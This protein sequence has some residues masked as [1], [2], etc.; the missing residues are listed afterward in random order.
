MNELTADPARVDLWLAFCGDAQETSLLLRYRTLLTVEERAQADR[1]YFERDRLRYLVTRALVRTVL[2]R[3]ARIEPADWRFVASEYG[4]PLI[5][6]AERV[7]SGLSFNITHTSDLVTLAVTRDRAIGIDT[8]SLSRDALLDIADRYFAPAEY[9]DLRALPATDQPLRFF[10]LWTLKE[11][12]IKARGMGLS[13]PLDRFAFDLRTPGRVSLSFVE[14]FDDQPQRWHLE[15]RWAT[16]Q[17]P[18]ALCVERRGAAPIVQAR[19]VVPLCREAS[20]DVPL[21]RR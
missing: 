16:P 12:Y 3:Y 15:Q 4:R 17:H 7:A 1:F 11:S 20:I 5:V 2:S 21:A 9:Q 6:D 18:L 8:E 19:R 14:G 10:E 13:I